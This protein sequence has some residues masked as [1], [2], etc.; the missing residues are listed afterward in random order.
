MTFQEIKSNAPVWEHFLKCKVNETDEYTSIKTCHYMN[1]NVH[2]NGSIYNLGLVHVVG[3]MP[4]EK[5][6]EIVSEKLSEFK[7]EFNNDIVSTTTDGA[8]VM[9]EFGH[10]INP[11]HHICYAHAIHLAVGDVLYVKPTEV[12]DQNDNF[13]IKIVRMTVK[14]SIKM[15]SWATLNLKI[16]Q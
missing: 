1:I 11:L 16:V 15:K 8:S 2:T 4:S 7:L 10:L 5:A 6:V 14:S 12:L 9:V 3:S 13:E